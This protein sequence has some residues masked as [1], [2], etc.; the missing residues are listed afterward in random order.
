MSRTPLWMIFT[1]FKSCLLWSN[2][3]NGFKKLWK[4]AVRSYIT[5]SGIVTSVL[6]VRW[7]LQNLGPI[8][9]N[10]NEMTFCVKGP[11]WE[12]HTGRK[13]L[14][15]VVIG[16][17]LK[18]QLKGRIFE[19][20]VDIQADSQHRETGV[21][22]MLTEVGEAMVCVYKLQI[23]LLW[24]RQYWSLTKVSMKLL[25]CSSQKLLAHTP[26]TLSVPN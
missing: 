14:H 16:H 23:G 7:L 8:C 11:A 10:R 24:R 1:F 3:M 18:I 2:I 19:N 26:L 21:P 15:N 6:N 22:D 17:K 13:F 9:K 25:H 12:S 20:V 4:K 5:C